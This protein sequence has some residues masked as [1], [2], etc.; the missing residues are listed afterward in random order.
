MKRSK[1]SR[2]MTK[3]ILMSCGIVWVAFICIMLWMSSA[4]AAD[5]ELLIE[6]AMDPPE[7]ISQVVTFNL[8][9]TKVPGSGSRDLIGTIPNDPLVT[10]WQGVFYDIPMGKTLDYYL[11]SIDGEGDS[12]WSPAY[13]F[14]LTGQAIIINMRRVK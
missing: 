11:E 12:G 13:Q 5:P 3:R 14:K 2:K 6:Y 4:R 7:S 1:E 9:V 10:E 8:Y